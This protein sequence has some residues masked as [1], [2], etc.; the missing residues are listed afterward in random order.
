MAQTPSMARL[1]EQLMRLPGIGEKTAGRLA[2]YILRADRQYAQALAEAVLAVKDATR[3]C[4]TCFALTETD[5]CPICTDPQRS[6][7]TICVVEDPA[8]LL[9][10][11]RAREFRGRYHVLHGALA[12]LDGVGPDE[13]KIQPLLVRLRDGAVREVILATNPTAEGEATALYLAKLIKPLGLKVT[14]IAHGIPV[15]GDLE[16]VD[17]MTVGRAL[18]GRREM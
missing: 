18:E 8:D 4:S 10:V 1:V 16:Y 5:P 14:R 17:V 2:L 11:E 3:L 7:E 12:P 15:G 6:A 13:L 9:A